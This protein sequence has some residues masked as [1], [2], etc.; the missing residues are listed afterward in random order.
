MNKGIAASYTGRTHIRTLLC[1]TTSAT[2]LPPLPCLYTMHHTTDVFTNCYV[3]FVLPGWHCVHSRGL[4]GHLLHTQ[5]DPRYTQ[6]TDLCEETVRYFLGL[7]ATGQK[8]VFINL[9]LMSDFDPSAQLAWN[10]Q[11]ARY[12]AYIRVTPRCTCLSTM[13][14]I[15]PVRHH[16]CKVSLQTV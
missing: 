8:L 1:G 14:A 3:S 9:T 2:V 4:K 7:L 12:L 5:S 13:M 16:L 10:V 11:S 15:Y 6:D